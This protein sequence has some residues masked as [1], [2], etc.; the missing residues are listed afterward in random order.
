L[1]DKQKAINELRQALRLRPDLTEWS[2]QDPDFE[3][4]RD[5]AGYKA[6]YE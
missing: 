2:Q 6:I 4:I 3:P 1:G 5:E